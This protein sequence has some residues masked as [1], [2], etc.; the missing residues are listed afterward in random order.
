MRVT[1][2]AAL[3]AANGIATAVE[4]ATKTA[5][6]VATAGARKRKAELPEKQ[7][8]KKQRANGKATNGDGEGSATQVSA[9]I[10][11]PKANNSGTSS[12]LTFL[13]ATLSFSYHEAKS[14]LINADPRFEDVFNK[15]K[16]RPYE[17]L[18]RVDPFR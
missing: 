16:C 14:H 15:M 3:A 9:N 2:S 10:T 7:T 5:E 17:H 4:T 13:P 1:R 11:V 18:E 8:T 6:Q 12:A